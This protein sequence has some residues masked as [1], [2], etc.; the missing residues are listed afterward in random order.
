MLTKNKF[1]LISTVT[2]L[3]IVFFAFWK[4]YPPLIKQLTESQGL[5]A[6]LDQKITEHQQYLN[7]VK[8][9]TAEEEQVESLYATAKQALPVKPEVEVLLLQLDGLLA[10]TKIN[11]SVTT[12]P[13]GSTATTKATTE[14]KEK[15]DTNVQAPKL[16]FTLSG[17]MDFTTLQGLLQQLRTL[18]RW[19][20]ITTI[21][22]KQSGDKTAATI[23]AEVF[24]KADAAKEFS[25]K[26][27]KF[28]ETAQ[29]LFTKY[30]SYATLPDVTKEGQFGRT[31]PLAPQ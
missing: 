26:D 20:K 21:D 13:I 9:L 25:G 2:F 14:D 17:E 27:V 7:L 31:D 22:L 24:T 6:E 10:S 29:A 23:S 15:S 1:F 30:Q 11:A 19:N 12:P 5:G 28:L 4:A 16:V 8:K 18:V 3:V